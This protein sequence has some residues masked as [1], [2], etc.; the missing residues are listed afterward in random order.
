LLLPPAGKGQPKERRGEAGHSRKTPEVAEDREV[1]SE[2][3]EVETVDRNLPVVESFL[4]PDSKRWISILKIC[5]EVSSPRR[6]N[7]EGEGSRGTPGSQSGR[8]Q[9]LIDMDSVVKLAIERVSSPELFL[10]TKLIRLRERVHLRTGRLRE[11]FREISCP[12]WKEPR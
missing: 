12:S 7:R 10:S 6:R 9:K 8:S 2:Y 4:P 5:L 11:E 1:R 3:V